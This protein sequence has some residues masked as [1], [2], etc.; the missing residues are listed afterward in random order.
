VTDSKPA[1]APLPGAQP[2]RMFPKLTAEQ[3]ARVALHGQARRVESGEVLAEAGDEYTHFFVVKTGQIDVVRV[4]GDAQEVIA[5]CRAGQF[6]GE[7]NLLTRRRLAR[8]D[9][10]YQPCGGHRKR[11][12]KVLMGRFGRGCDIPD[13][14]EH[15]SEE[16]VFLS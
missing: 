2:D 10:R 7:L 12:F 15:C 8:G 13:E 11:Q 14:D 1:S 6:T 9:I 4:S 16:T 3:V 5:I